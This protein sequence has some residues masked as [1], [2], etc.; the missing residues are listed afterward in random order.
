MRKNYLV[1]LHLSLSWWP[2]SVAGCRKTAA[3][4]NWP[5]FATKKRSCITANALSTLHGTD[6]TNPP[7]PRQEGMQWHSCPHWGIPDSPKFN[8]TFMP[9]WCLFYLLDTSISDKRSLPRSLYCT[10]FFLLKWVQKGHAFVSTNTQ[11]KT[12]NTQGYISMSCGWLEI[13]GFPADL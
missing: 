4:A 2:L 6:R 11:L 8:A 5:S 10:S 7:A 12:K 13:N 1:H 3:V 9:Y